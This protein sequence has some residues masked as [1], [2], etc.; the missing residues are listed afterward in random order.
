MRWIPLYLAAF[1]LWA[2]RALAG[3]DLAAIWDRFDHAGH[4]ATFDRH[5]V[6][7]VTC[8][9]LGAPAGDLRP[10]R[11]VCHGC[12]APGEGE[13]GGAADGVRGAPDT[14][15]TCHPAVAPPASHGAGWL[16]F[17][18]ADARADGGRCANCHSRSSCVDCHD[19]RQNGAFTTHDPSWIRTHGITA[20][21]APAS[22]DSCHAQAECLACHRSP[23]GFGRT[24]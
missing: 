15:A 16:A 19:R 12:H 5:R 24:P 3:D 2:S 22:C 1:A 13:L 17:H 21:A 8:H 11:G 23:A 9:A 6:G 10:D 20:R 18:G 14:C 7:C 4:A